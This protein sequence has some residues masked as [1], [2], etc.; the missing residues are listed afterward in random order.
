M[1]AVHPEPTPRR[2]TKRQISSTRGFVGPLSPSSWVVI[3]RGAHGRPENGRFLRALVFFFPAAHPKA[4]PPR[5][6]GAP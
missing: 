4:A 1:T 5:G 2:G 3:G 6:H